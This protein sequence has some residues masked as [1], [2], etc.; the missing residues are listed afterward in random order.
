[1]RGAP[2]LIQN[3]LRVEGILARTSRVRALAWDGGVTPRPSPNVSDCSLIIQGLV[4]VKQSVEAITLLRSVH[5][6]SL[7]VDRSASAALMAAAA[8]SAALT[9]SLSEVAR[10][11]S[12][13]SDVLFSQSELERLARAHLDAYNI[14]AALYNARELAGVSA[15]CVPSLFGS[16]S[17]TA[18]EVGALSSAASAD[19]T[20]MV[21][22]LIGSE[23]VTNAFLEELVSSGVSGMS[24]EDALVAKPLWDGLCRLALTSM[25]PRE[26]DVAAR[27]WSS[28]LELQAAAAA[29]CLRRM[30]PSSPQSRSDFEGLADSVL[31][32]PFSDDVYNTLL[33]IATARGDADTCADILAHYS[34]ACSGCAAE[35]FQ[36]VFAAPKQPAPLSPALVYLIMRTFMLHG[37]ARD[38]VDTLRV[39]LRDRRRADSENARDGLEHNLFES[40][41]RFAIRVKDLQRLLET[42]DAHKFPRLPP[43]WT[44]CWPAS[45]GFAVLK[46]T[47]PD[48]STTAV[49]RRSTVESQPSLSSEEISAFASANL[50]VGLVDLVLRALSSVGQHAMVR[51]LWRA[52]IDDHVLQKLNLAVNTP[53]FT[54]DVNR[55]GSLSTLFPPALVALRVAD[56]QEV[57]QCL[58]AQEAWHE[59]SVPWN[60]LCLPHVI[61][62]LSAEGDHAKV[63]DLILRALDVGIPFHRRAEF[64]RLAAAWVPEASALDVEAPARRGLVVERLINEASSAGTINAALGADVS[65]ELA[66]AVFDVHAPHDWTPAPES[67]YLR[68]TESESLDLDFSLNATALLPDKLASC[69]AHMRAQRIKLPVEAPLR[70]A[71]RAIL[72]DDAMLASSKDTST[73]VREWLLARSVSSAVAQL[74]SALSVCVCVAK[75]VPHISDAVVAQPSISVELARAYT[76]LFGLFSS[77]ADRIALSFGS[78]ASGAPLSALEVSLRTAILKILDVAVDKGHVE[79][80]M[81]HD[82]RFAGVLLEGLLSPLS[83]RV[84]SSESIPLALPLLRGA[85]R[86][87][88]LFSKAALGSSSLAAPWVSAHYELFYAAAANM[89]P[90]ALSSER[91]RIAPAADIVAETVRDLLDLRQITDRQLPSDFLHPVVVE[92]PKLWPLVALLARSGSPSTLSRVLSTIVFSRSPSANIK[93]AS[94]TESGIILQ[95][96]VI[97]SAVLASSRLCMRDTLRAHLSTPTVVSDITARWLREASSSTICLTSNAAASPWLALLT[98]THSSGAD[99]LCYTFLPVPC[100]TSSG[101]VLRIL[102]SAGPPPADDSSFTAL[103]DAIYAVSSDEDAADLPAAV[104]AD[105]LTAASADENLGSEIPRL[106]RELLRLGAWLNPTAVRVL[107]AETLRDRALLVPLLMHLQAQAVALVRAVPDLAPLSPQLLP[108]LP[109]TGTG[110]DSDSLGLLVDAAV[111]SGMLYVALQLL[112]T[113]PLGWRLPPPSSHRLSLL[114]SRAGETAVV[115]HVRKSF[116]G[117]ASNLG[118]RPFYTAALGRARAAQAHAQTSLRGAGAGAA[119]TAAQLDRAGDDVDGALARARAAITARLADEKVQRSLDGGK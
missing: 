72:V 30:T 114:S 88:A 49:F 70:M 15:E 65:F 16:I 97:A 83:R 117:A 24:A 119:E 104:V 60:A 90:R 91:A 113:A 41:R 82:K 63:S 86:T 51:A 75:E 94:F 47:D 73:I 99:S 74:S 85:A 52:G 103:G 5:A 40:A 4:S 118:S 37:R 105:L 39:H 22:M 96:N 110:V 84:G 93:S 78:S 66:R 116:L 92:A 13:S 6:A 7:T 95:N 55:P 50:A 48:L 81:A 44:I 115:D 80:L 62:S 111:A 25:D 46:D 36:N 2:H 28:L 57:A 58:Q 11:A 76:I 54:A 69:L 8:A 20:S 89:Q 71:L 26:A 68:P 67:R 3:A 107:A 109:V 45:E 100:L 108:V 106:T 10:L 102:P 31:S 18:L 101:R 56:E 27:L 21:D 32:I 34:A 33:R 29:R 38:V 79:E 12:L 14:R 61:A 1:M 17:A 77:L 59:R 42:T 19:P 23:P 9:P 53:L 43:L 87:L 112:Q 64:L 98:N 35:P